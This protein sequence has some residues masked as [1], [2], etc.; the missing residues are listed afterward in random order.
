MCKIAIDEEKRTVT[1]N[2]D[3]LNPQEKEKL[4]FLKQM[5]YKF[6]EKQQKRSGERRTRAYW[7][8]R[9]NNEDKEIFNLLAE[10][11]Y[12]R[13]VSFAASIIKLG[14]LAD[15]GASVTSAMDEYRNKVMDDF[16]DA[17]IFF[18]NAIAA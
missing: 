9:L 8:N 5:G 16:V 18:Q 2:T 17:K 10:R 13:A 4:L 1:A 11:S 12:S 6:V 7:M 14:K 15:K 3:K